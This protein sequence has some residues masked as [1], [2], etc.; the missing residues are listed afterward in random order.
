[1]FEAISR[2]VLEVFYTN[3]SEEEKE[4]LLRILSKVESNF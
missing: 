3:V 2:E 4:E 1:M